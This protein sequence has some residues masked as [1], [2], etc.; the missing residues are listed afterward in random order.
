MG[1]EGAIRAL[2]TDYLSGA[3]CPVAEE[4]FA[5]DA[6]R[7]PRLTWAWRAEGN[8]GCL[9]LRL[10]AADHADC[11]EGLARLDALL[12]WPGIVLREAGLSLAVRPV[13]TRI[14]GEDGQPCRAVMEAEVAVD[15]SEAAVD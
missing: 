3:G 6:L 7:L 12:P 9:T 14:E 10:W 13:A 11:V 1:H 8:R 4:G 5:P 15:A 2:L